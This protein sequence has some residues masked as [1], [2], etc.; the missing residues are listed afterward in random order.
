MN[1]DIHAEI[2]PADSD[3]LLDLYNWWKKKEV[4]ATGRTIT[5]EDFLYMILDVGIKTVMMI[6]DKSHGV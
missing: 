3:R 2:D 1:I 5:F 6:R 4:K